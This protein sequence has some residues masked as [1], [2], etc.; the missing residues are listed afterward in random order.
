MTVGFCLGTCS[1][2]KGYSHGIRDVSL[3]QNERVIKVFVTQQ[4][5]ARAQSHRMTVT[6]RAAWAP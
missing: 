1:Q 5:S 3:N 4:M 2:A 6:P